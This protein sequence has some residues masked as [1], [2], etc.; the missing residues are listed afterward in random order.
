MPRYIPRA[1]FLFQVFEHGSLLKPSPA[2]LKI[3]CLLTGIPLAL[4][5]AWA[6]T[7]V[8]LPDAPRPAIE[9]ESS[10]AWSGQVIRAPGRPPAAPNP[11]A[12]ASLEARRWAQSVDP[13]ETVPRLDARDKMEFWLHEELRPSAAVPAFV[14]AGYGQIFLNDPKYGSDSGAFGERLGAAALREASMRFFSSSLIP[15]FDGDDPRYFRAASGSIW[16]RTAWA[17]EQA[18]VAQ[19]D[20]GRR[21]FNDS[22]IFGHLAAAALTPLYYPPKSR[23][24]GVVMR[25]WG[26]SIAG[27]AGNNLFLEF[28]PD[29]VHRWPRARNFMLAPKS[30]TPWNPS[31]QG[32]ARVTK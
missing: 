16:H 1:I 11:R 6:Q 18:F 32:T 4:I 22:D 21:A 2:R 30:R 5:P 23:T 24:A 27:A 15:T 14:A 19:R 17:A 10:P 12:R 7:S 3:Y 28:W 26:A 9:L 13:G 20:S 8:S 25:V 29:V 31:L